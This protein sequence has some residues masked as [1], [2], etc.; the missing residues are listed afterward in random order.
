MPT[1]CFN[2]GVRSNIFV[3]AI[4]RSDSDSTRTTAGSLHEP[5]SRY[6]ADGGR[7]RINICGITTPP[8]NILLAGG[9]CTHSRL[10]LMI[11]GLPR[12]GMSATL[13]PQ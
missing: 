10:I 13:P 7:Y 1:L 5:Y 12:A 11:R 9:T 8:P 2:I 6:Y 3:V 4:T